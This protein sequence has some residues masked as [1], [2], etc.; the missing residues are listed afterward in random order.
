MTLNR[1]EVLAAGGTALAV[2]AMPAEAM[3][4]RIIRELKAAGVS[5][6]GDAE[7]M[8]RESMQ[9]GGVVRTARLA[10]GLTPCECAAKAAIKRG[11]LRVY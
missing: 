9:P 10:A 4:R 7:R 3:E 5:D 6:P 11:G 2:A 1:R 8:A